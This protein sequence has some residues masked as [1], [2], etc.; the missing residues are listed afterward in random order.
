MCDAGTRLCTIWNG[1]DEGRSATDEEEEVQTKEPLKPECLTGWEGWFISIADCR[2]PIADLRTW[3]TNLQ[4]EIGNRQSAIDESYSIKPL[5]FA[6][7]I[8]V[9]AISSSGIRLVSTDR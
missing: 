2:F 6:I 7:S 5:V 3:F 8:M 4:S 1:F 9:S